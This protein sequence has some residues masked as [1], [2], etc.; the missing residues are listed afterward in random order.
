MSMSWGGAEAGWSSS[1]ENTGDGILSTM[2]TEGYST[3]MSAGDSGAYENGGST[4]DPEYPAIDPATTSVGGTQLEYQGDGVTYQSESAWNSGGG[5]C[6]THFTAWSYQATN[7]FNSLC[8]GKRS[9]PDIALQSGCSPGESIYFGGNWG[10]VCG[11]SDAAPALAGIT[12]MMDAYALSQGSNCGSAG[13]RACAP[14]GLLNWYIWDQGISVNYAPHQPFY[15]IT[16]GDNDNGTNTGTYPTKTGYDLATGWGSFNALQLYREID[17]Y[18]TF[19]DHYPLVQ[20]AGASPQWYKS[21]ATVSWTISDPKQGTDVAASGIGGFSQEWDGDPGDPIHDATPG[22]ANDTFRDGPQFPNVTSG[23]LDVPLT[24]GCHTVNVRVWGNDGASH[25]ATEGGLC[26]DSIAPVMTSITYTPVSPSHDATVQI[27]GVATDTGCG[28]TGSCVNILTYWV[29]TASDGS[30]SGS[31]VDLGSSTGASGHLDWN[32][33]G[34]SEGVHAVAVDPW[35]NAGNVSDYYTS[36]KSKSSFVIDRTPPVSTLTLNG[37]APTSGVYTYPVTA[38]LTASDP[39]PGT[40]IASTSYRIDKGPLTL[41]KG[42][43][44][45]YSAGAG[46]HTVYYYSV[47]K[48]GNVEATKSVSVSVTPPAKTYKLTQEISKASGKVLGTVGISYAGLTCKLSKCV[49]SG[50]VPK[51]AVKFTEAPTESAH[52]F[53][54]WVVNGKTAKGRSIVV[55]IN[56][57][58]TVQ[59]VY[60]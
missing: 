42:P 15:D 23:W 35:D 3:M 28:T 33:S 51:V 30:D 37:H 59:A 31:W 13:T 25:D 48:A 56:A 20:F 26:Y 29:N 57:N 19:D 52:A 38:A 6:S 50:I 14:L 55:T 39:A 12:A 41:Y 8:S 21:E 46:V 32:T 36:A 9:S 18:N 43:F 10:G 45:I 11:T 22:S 27:N 2:A 40:G 24:Q 47:D 16:S 17:W 60:K 58:T 54:H 4:P 53:S 44:K 7:T 5:G 34:Y 1:D 49:Y